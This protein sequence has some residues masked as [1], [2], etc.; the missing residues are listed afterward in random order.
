MVL[1]T[2]D[3]DFE[4]DR[5]MVLRANAPNLECGNLT[6]YRFASVSRPPNLIASSSLAGGSVS[7][8]GLLVGLW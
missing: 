4:L 7:L 6:C 1:A 5:L 3:L 8:V 2:P